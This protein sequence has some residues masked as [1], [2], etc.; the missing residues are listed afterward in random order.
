MKYTEY[1]ENKQHGSPD[2][3]I[4]Y[5]YLDKSSEQYIMPLHWHREFEIIR[6]L[7][8]ELTVHLNNMVYTAGAGDILFV[9]SGVLHRAEPADCIYECAVYDLNM[10]RRFG[11]SKV[12]E[13]IMPLIVGDVEIDFYMPADNTKLAFTVARL[14]DTLKTQNPYFELEVY[15]I[16]SQIIYLLY[17]ENKIKS[18][19]KPKRTAHQNEVITALVDWIEQNYTEKITLKQLAD[20]SRINEKY[21]CRFFKEFTGQ[22][23]TDYINRIRIEHACIEMSVN[24]KSVTVAALDSGFNELSYFSKI[25]KRYKG[26]SPREYQSKYKI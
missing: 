25:F 17:S 1:R 12:T 3:P 10:L 18:R 8:G 15:G 24:D 7:K 9:G 20:I 4:E 11:S 13:Y 19:E 21:L 2:F 5:Y 16:I 14:F 22:T 23:P 26:M 6:V